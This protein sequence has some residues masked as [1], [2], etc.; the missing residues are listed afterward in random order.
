MMAAIEPRTERD[1]QATVNYVRNPRTSASEPKL[2]FCTEDEN[3]STMQTLPG[4]G[5]T[6]RSA[7]DLS[8]SLDR[9]GFILV[10]HVSAVDDFGLIEENAAVDQLY[11]DEMTKLLRETTGG[12]FAVMLGG[13]KKRFGES[14]KDLLAPLINAKP[15]RYPHADNTD[16]SAQK[17]FEQITAAAGDQ[18][19]KNARWALYNLW[20]AVSPPPQDFP[21]AIC[22]AGSVGPAD[23][24]VVTAVTSTRETGEMRHD[25]TGYLYNPQHRWHYYPDMTRDEVILFKAHDSREDLTRRVPH[26]AFTDPSCPAGTP[27]RAS[28]E[29]RG[30]VI[31]L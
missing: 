28:V 11:I 23:E 31:F 5:V 17:L 8:T 4:R 25:T 1:V 18:L 2:E 26:T 10:P 19:P 16:A 14:A 6:M 29:A 12:V 13:A 24:V 22:D 9:E 3:L 20:R 15:A 21:L 30:L 7:R 27:T